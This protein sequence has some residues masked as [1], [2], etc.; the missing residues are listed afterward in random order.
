MLAGSNARADVSNIHAVVHAE[1]V[2]INHAFGRGK[3]LAEWRLRQKSPDI[4]E[5][6]LLRIAGCTGSVVAGH[7]T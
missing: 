7:Q 2:T 5:T 6:V 1:L 3:R 4:R